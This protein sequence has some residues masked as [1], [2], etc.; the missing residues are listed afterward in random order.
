MHD[1]HHVDGDRVRERR[2]SGGVDPEAVDVARA[3]E[4]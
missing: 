3:R 1:Y 4:G 2:V